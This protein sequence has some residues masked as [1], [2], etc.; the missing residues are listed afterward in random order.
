VKPADPTRQSAQRGLRR[1]RSERALL[2]DVAALARRYGH[3]RIRTETQTDADPRTAIVEAAK[4]EGCDLIAL[5]SSRRVG[6][7][8][9]IG[10]TASAVLEQW[11][12]A[13]V[14]IVS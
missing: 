4:R 6:D 5:G 13:L 2:Q 8:L 10:Q 12:G 3:G 7:H 11:K 9:T 14:V 1:R